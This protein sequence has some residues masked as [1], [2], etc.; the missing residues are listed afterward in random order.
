[1]PN[2]QGS[3]FVISGPSGTGKSTLIERFLAEDKGVRFSVSYTTRAMRPHEVDGRNYRFVDAETFDRMVGEG[4]FLEWENVHGY[5]YGTPKKEV[6]APLSEGIDVVLDID[7]KGALRVK[8][9]CD[10]ATLIFVD[11]PSVDELIRRLSTRGEKEIEK[12][13]QRVREEVASKPLFT[14]VVINDNINR[15][16]DELRSIITEVR[17]Q[18]DG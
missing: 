6:T 13:M 9:E 3:L 5:C 11:T 4:G 12:R 17:R 1:M 2:K 16:Y 14:Y 7:V 10:R 8:K 18:H 15:A